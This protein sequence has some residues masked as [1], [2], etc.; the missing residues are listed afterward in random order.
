MLS[1]H[2]VMF[3][4]AGKRL[5]YQYSP[6]CGSFYCGRSTRATDNVTNCNYF[7]GWTQF[8]VKEEKLASWSILLVSE[9]VRFKL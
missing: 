3:L 5:L 2:S 4:E 7:L 6:N 9:I 1:G 8:S